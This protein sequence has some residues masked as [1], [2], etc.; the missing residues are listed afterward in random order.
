[1]ETPIY[2]NGQGL[3]YVQ[4]VSLFLLVLMASLNAF[5]EAPPHPIQTFPMFVIRNYTIFVFL[6]TKYT[7]EVTFTITHDVTKELQVF[8]L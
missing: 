6:T 7:A 1:M 2:I 4:T 8:M 5:V 3:L